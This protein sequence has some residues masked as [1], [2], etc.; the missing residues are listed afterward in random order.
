MNLIGCDTIVVLED[1]ELGQVVGLVH[2]LRLGLGGLQ[3]VVHGE[4][5]VHKKHSGNPTS[6]FLNGVPNSFTPNPLSNK[7]VLVEALEPRKGTMLTPDGCRKRNIPRWEG[8]QE[9]LIR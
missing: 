6:I 7:S 3:R 9:L 8:F 4:K 2:H 1:G 5:L